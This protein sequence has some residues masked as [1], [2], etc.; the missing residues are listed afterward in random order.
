MGAGMPGTFHGILARQ[1]RHASCRCCMI[2][3]VLVARM[4][5]GIMSKMSCITAAP[6]E[7]PVGGGERGQRSTRSR[8][9][10]WRR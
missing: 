2:V 4:P 7:L 6:G 8:Q 3:R 1:H 9:A 5:S 10:W